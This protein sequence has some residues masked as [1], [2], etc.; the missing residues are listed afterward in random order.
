MSALLFVHNYNYA[1]FVITPATRASIPFSLGNFIELLFSNSLFRFRMGLL[2]AVS[3]YLMANSK[4]IP[5]KDLILKKTKSLIVPYIVVSIIGLIITFM[6]ETAIFGWHNTNTTGMIGISLWH[7]KLRDYI[8]FIFITPVSFQLWYLRTIFMLALLSPVIRY[9][10]Q[11]FPLPA[12]ALVFVIWMFTNYLD[13]ETRDRC[14][15]FYGL[16]YYLRLYDKDV[17]KPIKGFNPY[18]ALVMYIAISFFR[19]TLAFYTP[20]HFGHLKYTLTIS[21]KLNELFSL[22]AIWFCFQDVVKLILQNRF[23]K[24]YCNCSFFVYAFHAPFINYVSQWFRWKGFYELKGSHIA[25]Y[26]LLPLLVMPLMMVLDKLVKRHLPRLFLLVS[27]GR[28][29]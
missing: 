26:I 22:Y 1:P 11:E 17:L 6:F 28:A 3:G 29:K 2:M 15:I 23:Y 27:G 18:V 13:G 14:F 8:N 7:F 5:Y 16:G 4:I 24:S 10:L 21:F 25:L 19:T 9:V 12:F 20:T